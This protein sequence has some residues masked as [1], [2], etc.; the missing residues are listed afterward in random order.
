MQGAVRA[1]EIGLG[2]SI[3]TF[4]FSIPYTVYKTGQDCF[5]RASRRTAMDF[6]VISNTIFIIINIT[7]TLFLL[8]WSI[9]VSNCRL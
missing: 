4:L 2:V 7:V 5:S 1:G 6:M 9:K 8:I 3:F